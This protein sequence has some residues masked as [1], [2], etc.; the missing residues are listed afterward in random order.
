MGVLAGL[1]SEEHY[2]GRECGKTRKTNCTT[3]LR[4]FC[5]PHTHSHTEQHSASLIEVDERIIADLFCESRDLPMNFW[6]RLF[7]RAEG[8]LQVDLFPLILL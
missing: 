6:S 8:L 5:G 2:C 7:V 3:Y 1:Q 4:S